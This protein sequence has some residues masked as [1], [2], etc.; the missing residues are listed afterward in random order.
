MTCDQCGASLVGVGRWVLPGC[1]RLCDDC[2]EPPRVVRPAAIEV[3][4]SLV[5]SQTKEDTRSR[6]N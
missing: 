6:I 3:V 5:F 2:K 4:C 1:R